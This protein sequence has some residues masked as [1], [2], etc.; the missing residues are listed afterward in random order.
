MRARDGSAQP[1][2]SQR[3]RHP[4]AQT[5]KLSDRVADA[6]VHTGGDLH[7]RRVRLERHAVTQAGRQPGE[8]LVR[9]KGQRPVV[10]VEEHE[11]L[12]DADRQLLAR[13]ARPPRR[14]CRD[15]RHDR[16]RG[17]GAVSR[18]RAR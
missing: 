18:R 9:A 5:G 13:R 2:R 10:R 14:P 12:L 7:H 4:V 1:L 15:V 16:G 11:L 17:E 6:E 8:H 3:A